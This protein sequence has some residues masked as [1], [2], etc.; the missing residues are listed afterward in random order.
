MLE[1][2]TSAMAGP[3]TDDH[4]TLRARPIR[5]SKSST[6]GAE[7]APL[8]GDVACIA[9]TCSPEQALPLQSSQTLDLNQYQIFNTEAKSITFQVTALIDIEA[10][11]VQYYLQRLKICNGRSPLKAIQPTQFQSSA[12]RHEQ[13]RKNGS[14]R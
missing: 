12:T 6:D 11:I 3:A 14:H 5:S 7:A 9:D 1:P 13:L 4:T 8:N 10:R 2:H